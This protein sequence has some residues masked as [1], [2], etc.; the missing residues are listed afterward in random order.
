MNILQDK[1]KD[2]KTGTTV[3]KTMLLAYFLVSKHWPGGRFLSV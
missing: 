1:D 2:S 3:Q